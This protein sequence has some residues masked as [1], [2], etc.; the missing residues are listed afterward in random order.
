MRNLYVNTNHTATQMSGF[1]WP[2]ATCRKQ[3]VHRSR[4]RVIPKPFEDDNIVA[5]G[6]RDDVKVGEVH[7]Y[8]VVVWIEGDDP[9]C[10]NDLIGERI[11]FEMH[12][13]MVDEDIE[14]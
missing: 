1:L 2:P 13:Q 5:A 10:T 3:V 12:M 6:R 14:E 4:G 9:D 11:G 7:K 8:T